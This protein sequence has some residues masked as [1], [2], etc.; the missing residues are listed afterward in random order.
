[1]A[2]KTFQVN[3]SQGSF[4]YNCINGVTVLFLHYYRKMFDGSAH[5]VRLNTILPACYFASNERVNN[6]QSFFHR[7]GYGE[8][9]M[10]VP[11]KYRYRI[12]ALQIQ[13]LYQLFSP[14]LYPMTMRA[15]L[16]PAC[17]CIIFFVLSP[18]LTGSILTPARPSDTTI[19]EY[20]ALVWQRLF[21]RRRVP[22]LWFCPIVG[23]WLGM[24]GM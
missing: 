2:F 4:T 11:A 13:M 21:R 5:T 19:E 9:S 14:V 10:L 6:I 16:P 12:H 22:C 1:M 7:A 23:P 15:M 8:Y 3:L 18:S 20:R 17:G 24:P